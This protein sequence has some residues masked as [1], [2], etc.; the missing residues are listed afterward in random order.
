MPSHQQYQPQH[1]HQPQYNQQYLPLK[2]SSS[3]SHSSKQQAK[4]Q[5]QVLFGGSLLL[6]ADFLFAFSNPASSQ[7]PQKTDPNSNANNHGNN[8]ARWIAL[9]PFFLAVFSSWFIQLQ[10]SQRKAKGLVSTQKSQLLFLLQT[11]HEMLQLAL[12]TSGL[13]SA[14][15]RT[16]DWAFVLM[17][18]MLVVSMLDSY[19]SASLHSSI[20]RVLNTAVGLGALLLFVLGTPSLAPTK[21]SAENE[22]REFPR[23]LGAAAAASFAVALSSP[24][25]VVDGMGMVSTP[26]QARKQQDDIIN[27]HND[28]RWGYMLPALALGVHVLML[29]FITGPRDISST[30]LGLGMSCPLLVCIAL[31]S[32]G[33]CASLLP[34]QSRVN[35]RM[36]C[37]LAAVL[38]G[39]SLA[40]SH[41]SLWGRL[42]LA[43]V[44]GGVKIIMGFMVSSWV[45]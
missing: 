5:Y 12:T 2:Q 22:S 6:W 45:P 33:S 37:N 26:T 4:K 8:S 3:S 18:P 14:F 38:L 31:L 40:D 36:G 39:A 9:L 1:C 11:G 20:L 35:V 19:E 24:L 27:H 13:L 16:M 43:Y 32:T 15:T 7:D 34:G 29:A 21:V 41:V 10:F 17:I 42:A 44:V 30:A 25:L 28:Q 23:T